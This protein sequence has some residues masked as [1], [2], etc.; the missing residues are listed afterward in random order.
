MLPNGGDALPRPEYPR[1]MLQRAEWVNLNGVWAFRHDPED[2]GLSAR[3]FD[4][5][6]WSTGAAERAE[7]AL[8]ESRELAQREQ[9]ALSESPESSLREPRELAQRA[10][11]ELA[12]RASAHIK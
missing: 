12:Q 7:S 10:Q 9:R 4:K 2:L 3:W 8:R 6:Q 5:A 1:P 11:R